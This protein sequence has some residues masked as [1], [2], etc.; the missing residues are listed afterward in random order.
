MKSF[1][2]TLCT[3][4]VLGG[5]SEMLAGK[6]YGKYVKFIASLACTLLLL[7]P[8][9]GLDSVNFQTDAGNVDAIIESTRGFA[10]EQVEAEAFKMAE[11][12]IAES[13]YAE[14]GIKASRVSILFDG[15]TGT[16]VIYAD[17][18]NAEGDTVVGYIRDCFKME[19]EIHAA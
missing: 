8:F 15:K 13:I 1:V 10:S 19:A 7:S 3:A 6:A 18:P 2:L 14:F 17:V 16:A 5:V 4:S 12:Y 11:E 9:T